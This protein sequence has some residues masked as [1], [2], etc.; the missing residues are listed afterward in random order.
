MSATILQL[1]RPF[2]ILLFASSMAAAQTGV[3]DPDRA[4]PG[5]AHSPQPTKD[6]PADTKH[7]ALSQFSMQDRSEMYRAVAGEQQRRSVSGPQIEVGAPVPD[8]VNVRPFPDALTSRIPAAKDYNYALWNG[9]VL[10]V[11]PASKKVADILRE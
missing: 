10:L 1:A 4:H 8:G 9:R 11:A 3:I 6:L 2:A 7:P 5:L